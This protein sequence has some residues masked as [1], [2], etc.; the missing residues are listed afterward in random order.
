MRFTAAFQT[1]VLAVALLSAYSAAAQLPSP[2]ENVLRL[3]RPTIVYKANEAYELR[4]IDWDGQNDRLWMTDSRKRMRFLAGVEWSPD[5]RRAAIAGFYGGG[6]YAVNVLNLSTNQVDIVTKPFEGKIV[7][8][9]PAWSRDGRSLLLA[10]FPLPPGGFWSDIYKLDLSSGRLKNLTNARDN[11]NQFPS[12]SPVE[13]KILFRSKIPGE[14][15][16]DIYVMN[17]D[18]SGA[19]RFVDPSYENAPAWSPDGKRIAWSS[20]RGSKFPDYNIFVMNA[21]G[22][23]K[24]PLTT[25]PNYDYAPRWSPCGK[26]LVYCSREW[27]DG[28]VWNVY[29]VHVE[30]KEVVQLTVNGG[31]DPRWVLAGKSRF[32]SVDPADKKKAPWG[33]IKEAEA[34]DSRALYRK[35]GND[36]L[37]CEAFFP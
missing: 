13:D 1:A 9:S 25:S 8:N 5:G 34:Q 4:L 11:L 16:H 37:A 19:V 36:G 22:S 23:N 15:N 31:R 7:L 14:D 20:T 27:V 6:N 26:W 24:E 17:A 28:A 2:K 29:R 33:K 30:T 32:L 3:E 18:G 21:D 10:G 35:G 12:W